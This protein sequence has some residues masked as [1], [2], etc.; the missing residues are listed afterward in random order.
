MSPHT[1]KPN[2][3]VQAGLLDFAHPAVVSWVQLLLW[4]NLHIDQIAD[5]GECEAS[6]AWGSG[7][8]EAG[9]DGTRG[10]KCGGDKVCGGRGVLG[11]G[12]CGG[13]SD[14]GGDRGLKLEWAMKPA[15]RIKIDVSLDN[16]TK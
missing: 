9:V 12:V 2:E 4:P 8:S 7:K 14:V 3:A 16:G 11:G 6:T 5:I 1:G 10:D 15:L 13:K